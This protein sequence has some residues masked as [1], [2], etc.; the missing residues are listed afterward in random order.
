MNLLYV[1]LIKSN[2]WHIYIYRECKS[3]RPPPPQENNFHAF[4]LFM[5]VGLYWVCPP[6]PPQDNLCG[7][8]AYINLDFLNKVYNIEHYQLSC[9]NM[10]CTANT[11]P[12]PTPPPLHT[13]LTRKAV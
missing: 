11:H 6:P 1:M 13:I 10:H 3:R 5:G 8:H 12:S 9:Y 7:S 2:I 4:F